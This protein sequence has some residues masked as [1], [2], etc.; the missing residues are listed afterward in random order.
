[1]TEL[2]LLSKKLKE[3]ILPREDAL[4]KG[5]VASYEEYVH[6]TGII[7]GLQAAL[8]A[9]EEAQKRYVEE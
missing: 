3:A 2:E 7:K 5:R 9:V 8:N 1:M 4:V 6:I